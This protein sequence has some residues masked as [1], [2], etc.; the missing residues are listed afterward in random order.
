MK[1]AKQATEIKDQI[2]QLKSRGLV[3]SDE[4]A[5]EQTLQNISYYRLAGYWWPMQAD[6]TQHT[7]KPDST[8]ENVLAIYNFDKELRLLLF[9]V[10]ERIEIA[11]RTKLIYHVSHEKSP[12]WFENPAFFKDATQH[13]KTLYAIDEELKRTK[14]VFIKEH[15]RQYHTDTRRPPAWKTLEI[16]SFGN[17][18]KLY[19]NLNLS[20][21]AKDLI[22]AELGTVNHTFLPGWL[23]SINQIRNICAHHGRLWNKNLPGRPKLLKNPPFAWIAD[24]PPTN[25][26]KM[27]YVHLCCMKY[28]LN[29]IDPGNQFTEALD[30][31]LIKYPNIDPGALGLKPNWKNE[32]LW[33]IEKLNP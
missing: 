27:L 4:S 26:H 19:G 28:L 14:E 20:I 16:A 8:F 25:E 2:A 5:A 32:P 33:A 10:I 21:K 22:A 1:Y 31:L 7:F 29:S 12:W 13:T 9:G 30:N 17:V 18:S 15:K 3:I 6:K 23:Q 11:F 24:V